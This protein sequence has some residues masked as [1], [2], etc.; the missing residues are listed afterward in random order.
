MDS[1]SYCGSF[2][3]DNYW[4]LQQLYKAKEPGQEFMGAD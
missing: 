1:I 4:P 2:V 3:V